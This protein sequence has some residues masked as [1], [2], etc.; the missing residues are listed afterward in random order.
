MK[1]IL[2]LIVALFATVALCSCSNTYDPV[3]STEEEARV[4]IELNIDGTRYDV[5]YELY[6]A[7]FIGNRAVVDGG[8]TTVWSGDNADE[9]ITKINEIIKEKAS[10]IYSVLHAAIKVGINPY[11]IDADNVVAEAIRISVEG[12]DN[13][14]YTGH[15]SYENYLS[16]LAAEG[17]NYSVADLLIRY[18]WAYEKLYTYYKGTTDSFGNLTGGKLDTSDQALLE[19]YNSD[20]AIRVLDAFFAEGI[21][22]DFWLE[23]FRNTLASKD[24]DVQKALYIITNSSVVS[25][26]LLIEGEVVGITVGRYSLEELYYSEYTS[27]AF[28]MQPGEV[29]GVIHVDGVNDGESDG[30]HIIVKLDKDEAYFNNQKD[31]VLEAYISNEIGKVI[32]SAKSTLFASAS[33]TENYSKITHSALVSK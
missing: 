29:S 25:S 30:A 13:K 27:V 10:Y 16:A 26:E 8:D 22:T 15:G 6:R 7:L 2:L 28:S 17:L 32:Y 9:Y 20:D 19:F 3:P 12:D 33:L 21:R 5:K 11:S 4:V 18:S 31:A 14:G 1:K 24:S 23:S